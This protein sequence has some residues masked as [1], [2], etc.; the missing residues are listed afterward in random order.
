M[1]DG[2]NINHHKHFA[3]RSLSINQDQVKPG[4]HVRQTRCKFGIGGNTNYG[5][6]KLPMIK[7]INLMTFNSQLSISTWEY[8][9]VRR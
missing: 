8:S 9:F 4:M 5:V 7:T 2:P 1:E 3:I 6:Y